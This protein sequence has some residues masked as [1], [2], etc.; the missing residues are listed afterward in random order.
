[1]P[2]VPSIARIPRRLRSQKRRVRSLF[3]MSSGSPCDCTGCHEIVTSGQML[4]RKR[5]S[6][7]DVRGRD[8]GWRFVDTSLGESWPRIGNC[9][10]IPFTESMNNKSSRERILAL[11]L[12]SYSMILEERARWCF[13][14]IRRTAE[15][16]HRHHLNPPYRPH[17]RGGPHFEIT[18]PSQSLGPQLAIMSRRT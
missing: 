7:F 12:G 8:D 17:K 4:R 1:M 15:G 13:S 16:L 18:T 6:E 2:R 5:C 14:F 9:K 11:I 3:E 10:Y